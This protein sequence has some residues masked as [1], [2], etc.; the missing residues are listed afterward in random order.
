MKRTNL[1]IV[2]LLLCLEICCFSGC[3]KISGKW[4]YGHDPE[5]PILEL[6]K[7]GSA[8]YKGQTYGYKLADSFIELKDADGEAMRLRYREDGDKLFLYEPTVFKYQGD[9]NADKLAGYWLSDSNSSF[10]FTATGIFCE[11]GLFTGVYKTNPEGTQFTLD[12]NE[13]FA[14]TTCYYTIEDN[15]MT[16]EY[17][18]GLVKVK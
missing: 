12:Y 2:F 1:L 17:P 8:V 9:G 10:E 4:A 14:D 15:Q 18:W 16:V 13:Y 7:D 6:K 3:S 11:D 5:T